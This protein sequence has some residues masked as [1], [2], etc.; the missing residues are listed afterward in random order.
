MPIATVRGRAAV[1][2]EALLSQGLAGLDKLPVTAQR[3]DRV[4]VIVDQV[5]RGLDAASW[6]IYRRAG[7]QGPLYQE[8]SAV[9]RA[10]SE[11]GSYPIPGVSPQLRQTEL[12]PTSPPQWIEPI[13][14]VAE[15]L[16]GF[17]AVTPAVG[18]DSN[19]SP[20]DLG[21]SP[22]FLAAAG[23]TSSL[24]AG[25]TG[26]DGSQWLVAIL[27]DEI[28]LWALPALPLLRVLLASSVT[29]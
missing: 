3:A 19:W 9:Y 11:S 17:G 12:S 24:S 15:Q 16:R 26:A 14:R 23:Y 8:R 2:I 28:S 1:P 21:I 13:P 18:Q 22:E 27:L 25:A 7:Q 20:G 29:L 10:T 5:A 6:Y 4:E